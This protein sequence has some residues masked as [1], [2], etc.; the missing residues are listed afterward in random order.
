MFEL[1]ELV[2]EEEL[3]STFEVVRQLRPHL[4]QENYV[5]EL[6]AVLD[7]GARMVGCFDGERVVGCGVF[8]EMRKLYTGKSIYVDD[9]VTDE[10]S[11]S[12]GV[13]KALLEW[14]EEEARRLGIEWVTLDSGVQRERAHKFYVREGYSIACFN[15]KKRVSVG[16]S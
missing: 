2:S 12:R 6:R 5:S 14:V 3:R 9:L 8:R 15:F 13:G 16:P 1:R 10:Q 7:G 11:R 4:T